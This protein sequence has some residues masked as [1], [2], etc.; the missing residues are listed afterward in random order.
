[1]IMIRTMIIMINCNSSFNGKYWVIFGPKLSRL[2]G[3]Q[4]YRGPDY[5][6]VI[7]FRIGE[8]RLKDCEEN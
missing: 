7:V 8:N 1:M 4:F 6:G 2:P 5:R 3:Y